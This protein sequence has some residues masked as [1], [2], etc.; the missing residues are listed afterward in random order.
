MVAGSTPN[1]EP[2]ARRLWLVRHGETDWSAGGRHTGSTD[3]PLNARGREQAVKLGRGLAALGIDFAAVWSSPLSR[4]RET[5]ALA[6]FA[7]AR[8][9]DDL[10]EWDY[11]EYEGTRTADVR[12]EDHNPDWLIWT[13]AIRHGE[14]ARNV[15]DRADQVIAALAG[16][17][18]AGDVLIFS[19]GHFLRILAARWMD[20]PG[21]RG[22]RL[23]L[24][25][26][27]VSI[28]GQ[29]HEYRVIE[30]WNAP[31]LDREDADED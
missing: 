17:S 22:Q 8:V 2:G 18:S 28:L 26:C 29:E 16:A 19:H 24:N 21:N 14:T 12:R 5:A 11:G 20:M 3:L 30:R 15:G 31:L 25:T 23:A 13:A 1:P 4:A 9:M 10:R 7:G 27:T 6:G